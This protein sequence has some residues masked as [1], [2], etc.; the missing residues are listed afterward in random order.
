ME[1]I[2]KGRNGEEKEENER[3]GYIYIYIYTLGRKRWD[4]NHL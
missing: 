1:E 4:K 2:V 3:E